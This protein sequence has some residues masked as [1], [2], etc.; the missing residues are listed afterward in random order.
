MLP[1]MKSTWAPLGIS[2]E[3]FSEWNLKNAMNFGSESAAKLVYLESI[4]TQRQAHVSQWLL[5]DCC[6]LAKE[7]RLACDQ[8]S[9][10]GC[11]DY[12]DKLISGKRLAVGL[13]EEYVAITKCYG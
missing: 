6:P 11:S 12:A 1:N 3:L 7:I 13:H 10:T 5:G 2:V 8:L 4:Y 9:V